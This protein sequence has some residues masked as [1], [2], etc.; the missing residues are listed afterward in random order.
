MLMAYR[1]LFGPLVG[2]PNW[3]GHVPNTAGIF[4]A[5]RPPEPASLY[6]VPP[7]STLNTS[8]NFVDGATVGPVSGKLFHAFAVNTCDPDATSFAPGESF[9]SE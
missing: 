6:L 5:A 2:A 9:T 3:S 8:Q 1:S 7:P 4:H